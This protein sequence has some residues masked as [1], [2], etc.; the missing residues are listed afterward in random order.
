MAVGD[1]DDIVYRL[2]K[3]LPS[4]WFPTSPP[5]GPSATP[6]LDAVLT[7]IAWPWYWLYQ[8]LVYANLQTRITTATDQFLDI[9]ALDFLASRIVRKPGQSDARWRSRIIREILR[10]RVTRAALSQALLDLTGRSPIIFEPAYIAD[11]HSYYS[12]GLGTMAYNTGPAGWGSL[13][14]PFQVFVTAFRPHTGGI[15][16]AAGYGISI[17]GYGRGA[18]EYVTMQQVVDAVTDE[19]IYSTI[20]GT[21][22][23][24]SIAWTHIQP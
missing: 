2:R 5:G 13:Q 20:A 3:V 7:G 15:P 8:F 9:I 19:E 1:L 14:L 6:V 17:G 22:P 10:P 12:P 16:G 18:I 24:G 11:T 21:M 23:A 4:R